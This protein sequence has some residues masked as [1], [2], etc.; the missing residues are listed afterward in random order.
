MYIIIRM[1]II[2]VLFMIALFLIKSGKLQNR[3]LTFVCVII[4]STLLCMVPFENLFMTFDSAEDAFEYKKRE[5]VVLVV[6]GS[7][8]DLVV[9]EDPKTGDYVY[10][11]FSKSPDGWRLGM[12]TDLKKVHNSVSEDAVVEVFR[13]KDTQDHYIILHDIKGNIGNLS[14]AYGNEFYKLGEMSH[15]GYVDGFSDEY[16]ICADGN[17]LAID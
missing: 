13:Y 11:A 17:M 8:S 15:F 12:G 9:G 2:S 5:E 4:L 10:C 3:F 7:V 6:N 1:M 14:D 16:E